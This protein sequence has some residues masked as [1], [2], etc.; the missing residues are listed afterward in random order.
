M[1]P[2]KAKPTPVLPEDVLG[3]TV[4]LDGLHPPFMRHRCGCQRANVLAG[5]STHPLRLKCCGCG[6]HIGWLRAD[7]ARLVAEHL[8]MED[9]Q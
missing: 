6:Q 3:G 5:M 2:R 7:Q 4:A 9:A 1:S 8:V